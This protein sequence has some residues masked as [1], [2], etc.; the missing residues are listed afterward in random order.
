MTSSKHSL[1]VAT[2]LMLMASSALAQTTSGGSSSFSDLSPG[3]QKIARA[4]PG[5]AT[6]AEWSAA[7]EPQPHRG[8]ER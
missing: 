2:A 1:A 8:A 3:N 6:H 7:T 4:V 5:A